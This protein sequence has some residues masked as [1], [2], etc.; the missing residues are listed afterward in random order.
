M[1]STGLEPLRVREMEVGEPFARRLKRCAKVGFLDVHV[2][3]VAHDE[4][5]G[6]ADPLAKAQRVGNGHAQ[7]VLISVDRLDVQLRAGPL[8]PRGETSHSLHEDELVRVA[9]SAGADVRE[10]A[11]AT[12]DRNDHAAGPELAGERD[13]VRQVLASFPDLLGIRIDEP[14]AVSAAD[15][16][17]RDVLAQR[18][19]RVVERL[20]RQLDRLEAVTP[21]VVVPLPQRG[22]RHEPILDGEPHAIPFLHA[23]L[24]HFSRDALSSAAAAKRVWRRPSSKEGSGAAGLLASPESRA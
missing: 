9:R 21:R 2:E 6:A 1:A 18:D 23:T 16:R 7:V 3:H 24:T 8:G 5:G 10:I 20:L 19:L 12:P 11:R 13:Q 14:A 4:N 17:D 15:R 22:A